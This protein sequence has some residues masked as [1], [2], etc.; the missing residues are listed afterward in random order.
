M[1]HA[2]SSSNSRKN[3]TESER[4]L[5]S[6]RTIQRTAA[7]RHANKR[8]RRFR[9]LFKCSQLPQKVASAAHGSRIKFEHGTKSGLRSIESQRLRD[10]FRYRGQLLQKVG[11]V[12]MHSAFTDAT[13]QAP[14]GPPCS[15]TW[16]TKQRPARKCTL[17]N[18]LPRFIKGHT[19]QEK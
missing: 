6:F 14:R 1:I 10:P 12:I 5:P 17:L 19:R 18:V 2:E 8:C 3:F 4:S 9:D 13:H 15:V 11:A 16:M 7:Q